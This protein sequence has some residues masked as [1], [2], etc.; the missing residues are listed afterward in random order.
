[1]TENQSCTG[2][3]VVSLH[4]VFWWLGLIGCTGGIVVSSLLL[5]A[6]ALVLAV[7]LDI[8]G[9]CCKPTTLF[10]NF[11]LFARLPLFY[12]FYKGR[13]LAFLESFCTRDATLCLSN[14]LYY[15]GPFPICCWSAVEI[16]TSYLAQLCRWIL[17]TDT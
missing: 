17:A 1:M 4:T 15:G 13:Y 2:L 14:T 5:A 10:A 9:A 16:V 12:T 7:R 3:F 8:C 11:L 6:M